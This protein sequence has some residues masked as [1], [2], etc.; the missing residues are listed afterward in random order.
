MITLSEL[1]TIVKILS[2]FGLVMILTAVSQE[3]YR[4]SKHLERQKLDS[5]GL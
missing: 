1:Y 3:L 5:L 2:A 4:T